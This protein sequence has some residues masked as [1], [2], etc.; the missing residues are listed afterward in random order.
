VQSKILPADI[1]ESQKGAIHAEVFVIQWR[2]G[3]KIRTMDDLGMA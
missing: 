2:L 1:P 3:N